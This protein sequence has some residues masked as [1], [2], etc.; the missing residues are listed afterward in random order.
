ME[1]SNRRPVDEILLLC[2]GLG[3][4]EVNS[5][6]QIFLVCTAFNVQISTAQVNIYRI[7]SNIMQSSYEKRHP[8]WFSGAKIDRNIQISVS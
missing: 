2:L 5:N 1:L 7:K 3:Y 6:F 4:T 8:Y